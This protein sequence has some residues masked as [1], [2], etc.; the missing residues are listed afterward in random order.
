[1][2]H[3]DGMSPERRARFTALLDGHRRLIFKVANAYAWSPTDREDL[4]Q[5]IAAQLWRAFPRYDA[6]R[7]F[8]TWT[9][10]IALNVAISWLRREAERRR[11]SVSFDPERHETAGQAPEARDQD[12][13]QAILRDFMAECAPLDRALL[14]LYLEERSHSE[15][16]E[17][18]GIS[19][20]NVST[21][22]SRLKE[23][24]RRFVEDR[25][26]AR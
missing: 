3:S 10:R 18:L 16:A 8:S 2:T 12:R 26:G 24:L 7:R 6:A 19:E 22:L 21:K 25:H 5:E 23:R 17:V 9:Y 20:T 11:R 1:M 13:G 15:T 14:L 4:I